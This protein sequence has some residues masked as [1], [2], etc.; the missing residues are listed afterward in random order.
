[1]LNGYTP[2]TFFILPMLGHHPDWYPR[3]RD[4]FLNDEEHPEY[5]NCI[6]VFTRTGGVNREAYQFEI[7]EMQKLPGFVADFDDSFDST[8]ASWIFQVPEEW[9]Q[10]FELLKRNE[11]QKVSI[12][13]QRQLREIYPKLNNEFDKLFAQSD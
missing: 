5:D 10:D 1:M 8:Y 6:H 3:F 4:C 7:E 12:E 2:A 9:K 13:Y 11:F